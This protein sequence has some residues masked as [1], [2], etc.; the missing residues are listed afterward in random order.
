MSIIRA[1]GRIP[2]GTCEDTSIAIRTNVY[3]DN[4]DRMVLEVTC[5]IKM[6][7]LK[8]GS[9]PCRVLARNQQYRS[10]NRA[11]GVDIGGTTMIWLDDGH[12]SRSAL[13]GE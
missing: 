12:E 10:T 3:L 2:E 1:L 4:S 7:W 13:G 11:K 9:T 5:E 6:T 8:G